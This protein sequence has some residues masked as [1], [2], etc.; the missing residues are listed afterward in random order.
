M[1]A[2]GNRRNNSSSS[3]LHDKELDGPSPYDFQVSCKI[4][5]VE[6]DSHLSKQDPIENVKENKRCNL[7]KFRG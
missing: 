3:T 5:K 4:K 2:N 1:C 7:Q 6:S